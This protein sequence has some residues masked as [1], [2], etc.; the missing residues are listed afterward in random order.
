[1]LAESTNESGQSTFLISQLVKINH[2]AQ[3]YERKLGIIVSAFQRQR[4]RM[5]E[6]ACISAGWPTLYG[7]VILPK[8]SRCLFTPGEWVNALAQLMESSQSQ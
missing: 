1:M 5:V 3:K 7:T 8:L 4:Y 2:M 6:G